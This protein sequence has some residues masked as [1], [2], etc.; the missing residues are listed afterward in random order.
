M[1]AFVQRTAWRAARPSESDQDYDRRNLLRA[2]YRLNR[3]WIG[4]RSFRTLFEA[5]SWNLRR[6]PS[7][8]RERVRISGRAL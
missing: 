4:A 8:L 5:W 3:T 2:L 7:T 1:G 6:L